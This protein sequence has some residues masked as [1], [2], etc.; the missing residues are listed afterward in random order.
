MNR[1]LSVYVEPEFGNAS[2]SPRKSDYAATDKSL[3][4][5]NLEG[6]DWGITSQAIGG[7]CLYYEDYPDTQ[8]YEEWIS[9]QSLKTNA[10]LYWKI[11]TSKEEY[12]NYSPKV[13]RIDNYYGLDEIL[14][15]QHIPAERVTLIG[16]W[17]NGQFIPST[18]IRA[19]IKDNYKKNWYDILYKY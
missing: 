2:L 18:S 11:Y 6:I 4:A 9:N 5:V 14:V 1:T 12:L 16:N 3:F 17:N 13:K 10:K 8:L 15:P 7:F 19:F